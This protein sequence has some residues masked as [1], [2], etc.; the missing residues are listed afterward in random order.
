[1]E[2]F[3]REH[4]LIFY[5]SMVYLL[6]A[7][8]IFPFFRYHINPD[9]ISHI[10]IAEKYASGNL[11]DAINGYWGPL[12]S[13]LIVP[14][15]LTGMEPL[16]GIRVVLL[17]FGLLSL[18]GINLLLRNFDVGVRLR[19]LGTLFAIP[20]LLY[21]SFFCICPDILFTTFFI[22]YLLLILSKEYLKGI[23]GGIFAGI[24]GA[25]AYLSK[26][27]AFPFFLIHFFLFSVLSSYKGRSVLKNFFLGSAVFLIISGLWIFI[28]SHKYQKLIIG[29]SGGYNFNLV[30][31]NSKGGP[32]FYEGFFA[33]PDPSALSAWEESSLYPI[34]SWSPFTSKENFLHLIKVVWLNIW[35][36]IKIHLGFSILI[37][38]ILFSSVKKWVKTKGSWQVKWLVITPFLLSV[39]YSIFF[40]YERHFWLG[41]IAFFL[42]ALILARD[43]KLGKIAT[44]VI[45]SSFLL[46]PLGF[47][48]TNISSYLKSDLESPRVFFEISQV[49][50]NE[51]GVGGNIA[52]NQRWAESLYLSYFL[53]ARYY[54]TPENNINDEELEKKLSEKNIDY[55]FFWEHEFPKKPAFLK[56][57]NDITSGTVPNLKVY[58]F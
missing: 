25:L 50:K 32:F 10:S 53:G 4:R 5:L 23:R 30:G 38:F 58:K 42:L 14:L 48:Y 9:G 56:P 54:G 17:A 13:W 1:M 45:L 41:Y 35:E 26:A 21:L 16:I 31:P 43:L 49:L 7:L 2:K 33:P 40:A 39:G 3:F 28:I 46:K 36:I 29:T 57:E 52:S 6:G 51:Y 34:E 20:L 22:Y 47:F 11:G 55:Y 44:L 12:L 15:I 19:N 37:P 24:L 18:L 8:L 27:F